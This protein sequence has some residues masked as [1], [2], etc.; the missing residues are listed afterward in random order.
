MNIKVDRKY[1]ENDRFL[2]NVIIHKKSS[3]QKN[4]TVIKANTGELVSS[5]G[6][7]I[8]QLVLKD[9]HYYEDI[10]PKAQK[11]RQKFP[12]TRANFETYT[13]NIELHENDQDLEED[14][15]VRTDKMKNISRL[16]KDI[17]SIQDNN[18]KVITA[19]SKNI[20]N[21]MGAFVPLFAKDTTDQKEID[22]DSISPYNQEIT[23][24][25]PVISR[26]AKKGPA[27][28]DS[29]TTEPV[30]QPEV[31]GNEVKGML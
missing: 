10:I 30:S 13:I 20:S 25:G 8:I 7:E 1:G 28:K 9:G 5:E 22:L 11:N 23:S 18:V 21:R 4:T 15:N 26:V 19:F 24:P 31:Y 12:F 16:Q 29:T 2:E 14:R 17:D 27:R 6:S 3:L